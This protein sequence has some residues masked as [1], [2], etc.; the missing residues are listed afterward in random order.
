[1][2]GEGDGVEGQVPKKWAGG[3]PHSN[4]AANA[5]GLREA[6]VR[7]RADKPALNEG[8]KSATNPWW[9]PPS[10]HDLMQPRE[11]EAFE[12]FAL[13]GEEDSAPPCVEPGRLLTKIV[14][15]AA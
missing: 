14:G 12:G 7:A 11:R 3:P 4:P 6:V 8:E 5:L 9:K 13:I 15:R 1:M 2:Q 10:D